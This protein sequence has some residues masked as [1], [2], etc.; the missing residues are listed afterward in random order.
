MLRPV[1]RGMLALRYVYKAGQRDGRGNAM[2]VVMMMVMKKW[3]R[4]RYWYWYQEQVR[5]APPAAQL[6]R[7]Q[8]VYL[9]S[10]YSPR[11]RA[12][13]YILM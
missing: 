4:Y 3:Y 5:S 6:Y 11:A 7:A 10:A 8:Y 2:V 13:V 1:G 9:R 12:I